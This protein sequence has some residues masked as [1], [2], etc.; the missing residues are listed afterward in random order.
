MKVKIS[1]SV[2]TGLIL[3][4]TLYI[5]LFN[6]TSLGEN[7]KLVVRVATIPLSIIF[8]IF[9]NILFYNFDLALKLSCMFK[10]KKYD[11]D[12]ITSF[13]QFMMMIGIIFLIIYASVLPVCYLVDTITINI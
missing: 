7:P 5:S 12:N 3:I 11:I 6:P 1:F 10:F 8:Y 13:Y 9:G 2:I 4:A